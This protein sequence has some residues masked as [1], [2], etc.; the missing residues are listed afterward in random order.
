[1]LEIGEISAIFKIFRKKVLNLQVF[2]K[3]ETLKMGM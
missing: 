2:V 3:F 1:M